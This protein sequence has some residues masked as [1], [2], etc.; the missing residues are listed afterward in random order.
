MLED[1]GAITR[2]RVT[3]KGFYTNI[4]T[5]ARYK[6]ATDNGT[7]AH[8]SDSAPYNMNSRGE[9]ISCKDICVTIIELAK[10]AN[11]KTIMARD[12]LYALV[13]EEK[14]LLCCILF[15]HS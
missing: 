7:L 15:S 14:S 2:Q 10:D 8:A 12:V 9:Y 6:H 1:K 3:V 13:K 4:C 11:E 5:H